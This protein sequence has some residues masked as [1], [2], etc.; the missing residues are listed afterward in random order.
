MLKIFES[1]DFVCPITMLYMRNPVMASD[2]HLYEKY[3]IKQWIKGSHNPTSPLTRELITRKVYQAN[4]IKNK[5][6]NIEK[7]EKYFY[8]KRYQYDM[9]QW[10]KFHLKYTLL[11]QNIQCNENCHDNIIH[12]IIEKICNQS[13]DQLDINSL[14]ITDR[15]I[16]YDYLICNISTNQYIKQLIDST[17][18]DDPGLTYFLSK[19]QEKSK[20]DFILC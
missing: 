19:F 20:T 14:E 5:I 1:N 16:V 15:K 10:I 3:A 6:D 12:H 4:I 11:K 18:P 8:L 17:S 7:S 13:F 9:K 2:G